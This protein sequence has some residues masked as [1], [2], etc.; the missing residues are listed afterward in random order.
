MADR[1]RGSDERGREAGREGRGGARTTRRRTAAA[2]LAPG[3][4]ET[5]PVG[6]HVNIEDDDQLSEVND[7]DD[8]GSQRISSENEST[9]T[10]DRS[11][12]ST[13]ASQS[14][15]VARQPV[16]SAGMMC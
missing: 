10:D 15:S 6:L 16:T 2:E 4:P 14:A 3:E 11:R 9:G 13:G 5:D 8:Q 1:R 12:Q 7:N